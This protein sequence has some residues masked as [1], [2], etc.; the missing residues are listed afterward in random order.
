MEILRNDSDEAEVLPSLSI[1][2]VVNFHALAIDESESERGQVL[3]IASDTFIVEDEAAS[4]A[5]HNV[6]LTT[7]VCTPQ[8]SP[9]SPAAGATMSASI[10]H[11]ADGRIVC[12]ESSCVRTTS[13]LDILYN[14]YTTAQVFGP[15]EWGSPSEAGWRW[16]LL[17]GLS[18]RRCNG[19]GFV[20]SDGRFAVLGVT[21][22]ST[23]TYPRECTASFDV[24]TLDEHSARW[25]SLPPLEEVCELDG[26]VCEV[27]GECVLV[28]G[29]RLLSKTMKV[30]EEAL[31]RWRTLPC[32]LPHDSSNVFGMCT[33][34]M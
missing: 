10:A 21:H 14:W 33:A 7:G 29:G 13:N 4:M 27:I 12:V 23:G 26:V 25:D 32:K 19:R 22:H 8:P 3:L 20:L 9:I 34:L 2:L 5:I 11:M 15:P 24:L 6:D 17:P 1:G 16:K 18:D 28:A 30:Y 31:G